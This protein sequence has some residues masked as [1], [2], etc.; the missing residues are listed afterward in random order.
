MTHI[1]V[2]K[3]TIIGS[4]NCLSPGRH[5][6]IIWTNAGIL[7]IRTLGTNSSEILCKIHSFSFKKMHLKMSSAKGRLFSLGLNELR[8]SSMTRIM[9]SACLKSWPPDAGFISSVVADYL[10]VSTWRF[11]SYI[12]CFNAYICLQRFVEAI[13]YLR[14]PHFEWLYFHVYWRFFKFNLGTQW[15]TVAKWLS[16]AFSLQILFGW[17][18]LSAIGGH[19]FRLLNSTPKHE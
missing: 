19:N 5:Q 8:Q 6:A 12:V 17:H 18:C 4:D 11:S 15:R 9:N 16:H 1:W 2:S 14:S 13:A 7:S 10:S 3:L